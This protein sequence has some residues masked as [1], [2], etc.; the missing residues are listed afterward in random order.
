MLEVSG[1]VLLDEPLHRRTV[2]LEDLFAAR[3]LA[4][5]WALCPQTS[6]SAT[7]AG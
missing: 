2:A 5:P 3:H 6:D 7:V 1:V 4:A